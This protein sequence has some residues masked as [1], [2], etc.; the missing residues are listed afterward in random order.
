MLSFHRSCAGSDRPEA[1]EHLVST[2]RDPGFAPNIE[3]LGDIENPCKV[4]SLGVLS[5]DGP[6]QSAMHH[7]PPPHAVHRRMPAAE[8]G[9]VPQEM[10]QAR[11][12]QV[13]GGALASVCFCPEGSEG[14][15]DARLLLFFPGE[16]QP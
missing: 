11:Q 14:S 4:L 3:R 16:N 9:F 13:A 10:Q 6:A 7:T 2:R 8:I 5:R 12:R 1:V 15:G